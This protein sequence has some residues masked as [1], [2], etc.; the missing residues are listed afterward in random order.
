MIY[1][2]TNH[3]YSNISPYVPTPTIIEAAKA[4][5]ENHTVED[6]TR[7]EADKVS[8]DRTIAYILDV[9]FKADFWYFV[10]IVSG[11]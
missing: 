5:Y 8:T 4:L 7:H 3:Y 1:K 6:I 9:I 2:L 10:P 11:Y